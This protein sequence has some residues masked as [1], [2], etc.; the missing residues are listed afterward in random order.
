MT[1]GGRAG[2]LLTM[3]ELEGRLWREFRTMEHM[4]TIYCADH[5]SHS[6]TCP[7]KQCQAFLDYAERRLQK[8]PYAQAKPTCAK[9]PIHC[10]KAAQREQARVIMRYSGPRMLRRHPWYALLHILDKLRRVEH[11]LEVRARR[12]A[13]ESAE[14]QS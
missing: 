2:K 1:P 12:R 11:P 9:C 5:H 13:T 3:P 6:I 7:C 10:Y 8:C 4:V 14:N